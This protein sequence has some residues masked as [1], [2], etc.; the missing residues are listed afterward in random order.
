MTA[1]R[2]GLLALLAGAIVVALLGR[3]SDAPEPAFAQAHDILAT[4]S[5]RRVFTGPE[6]AP[7]L[8]HRLELVTRC[9]TLA[10][11]WTSTNLE[12][13]TPDAW[14]VV[15]LRL[16]GRVVQQAYVGAGIGIYE[17]GPARLL[18]RGTAPPGP[19]TV[20]A[21]LHGG[22]PIAAWGLP[23]TNRPHIGLDTLLAQDDP[24]AGAR[25]ATCAA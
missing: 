13:T 8:L 19:H 16:D 9:P 3:P 11:E 5:S 20:E 24:P 2:I 1:L 10:I 18:W 17:D 22:G 15:E 4:D 12:P 6:R 21:W 14:A 23:Y 7:E 25:P